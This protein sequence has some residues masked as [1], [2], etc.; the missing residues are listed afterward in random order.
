MK[1]IIH[2]L[3]HG[4]KFQGETHWIVYQLTQNT[5]YQYRTVVRYE[6]GKIPHLM[7]HVVEGTG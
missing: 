3:N 2:I 4:S 1:G 5:T 6:H 7:L